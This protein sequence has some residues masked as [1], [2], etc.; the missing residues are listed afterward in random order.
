MFK[1]F[2]REEKF[3]HDISPLGAV[4][5]EVL[6]GEDTLLLT[7]DGDIDI[8]KK[9]RILTYIEK[10][11]IWKEFIVEEIEEDRVDNLKHIY[12]ENSFYEL[13]GDFI[14]DKRAIESPASIALERAL[15]T[16]RW[17]S[18]R[19]DNLG[20][21]T[22]TFYRTN[23]KDAVQEICIAWKGE[24]KTRIEISGNKIVSR[25]IDILA[26]RGNYLGERFVT[27]EN[28]AGIKRT[29]SIDSIATAL[30]GFGK[31][32]EIEDVEGDPTGG[33]GRRIDFSSI[34]GGKSYVEDNEARL[35]W[36]R[37]NN[38]GTMSHI[39]GKVEFDDCE[40]ITEL[41]TLTTEHL[42]ILKEPNVIYEGEIIGSVAE[43]GDAVVIIDNDHIPNLRLTA[44]VFEIESDLLDEGNSKPVLGNYRQDISDTLNKQ[45]NFIDNFRDKQGIWDR[46]DS[47]NSDG[48]LHTQ[49]LDGVIDV[50]KNKL[51]STLSGWYTDDHGNIVLDAVDGSSSMM[52]SGAGF[53]IANT[54]LPNSNWSYR[55]FGTGDGFTADLITAGTLDAGIVKT[56]ILAS[57]DAS[58]WIN[59]D[60]GDFDFTD[61]VITGGV[62]GTS[63]EG[64]RIILNESDSNS[65]RVY[66]DRTDDKALAFIM[67]YDI[68]GAGTPEEAE[69][70]VFLRT[71]NEHA[72]KISSQNA[73]MSIGTTGVGNTVFMSGRVKF[74]G[75]ITVGKVQG[76]NAPYHSG[77]WC[78]LDYDYDNNG[79]YGISVRSKNGNVVGYLKL[80]A[81]P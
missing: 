62:I 15:L 37:L 51:L 60:S 49:Y 46:A 77:N 56:G 7:I 61:G 57:K 64:K 22:A 71:E 67:D 14:E 32:E 79:A 38:D 78:Y 20:T 72:L 48:N 63:K 58:V 50:L 47:F 9:Y 42:Q 10:Y 80:S 44:R 31:G 17:S 73:N 19:V 52:L 54:K 24:L 28:V 43:L 69:K 4:N 26:Q 3:L 40:D 27:G 13:L 8:D 45:Q 35:K 36:G 12:A 34:N 21:S 74:V 1:L 23:A 66:S 68:L 70:R 65:M 2:N 75:D 16:T 53:M 6:N 29:I 81:T 55:T 76:I 18:G 25:Y 33:F 41:L 30:Y 59:L 5:K 39:F 11:R